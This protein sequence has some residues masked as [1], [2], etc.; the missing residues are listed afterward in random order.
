MKNTLL[1]YICVALVTLASSLAANDLESAQLEREHALKSNAV[2]L[3]YYKEGNLNDAI[4]QF[5]LALEADFT[6]ASIYYNQGLVY[7]SVQN[8]SMAEA[9]YQMFK[10]LKPRDHDGYIKL[11][12]V[13]KNQRRLHDSLEVLEEGM[14]KCLKFSGGS[15]SSALAMTEEPEIIDGYAYLIWNRGEVYFAMKNFKKAKAD[16]EAYLAAKPGDNDAKLKILEC[17][18]EL[19]N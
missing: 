12:I 4:E 8:L 18:R 5:K 14:K 9:N 13:L 2:G 7:E 19:S 3:A 10:T 15:D 6:F 1:K 11:S 17:E 16:Y